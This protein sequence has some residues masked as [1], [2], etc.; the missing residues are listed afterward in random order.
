M[1]PAYLLHRAA[2]RSAT[3]HPED[4]LLAARRVRMCANGPP[5]SHPSVP[6]RVG[7]QMLHESHRLR[8]HRGVYWCTT[9]RQ[10]A[11]HAAGKKSR[12]NRFRQ[13]VPRVPDLCRSRR[14]GAHRKRTLSK[15]VSEL[16]TDARYGLNQQRLSRLSHTRK[17]STHSFVS[18]VLRQAG[19]CYMRAESIALACGRWCC[20]NTAKQCSNFARTCGTFGETCVASLNFPM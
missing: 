2:P 13:L 15:S 20:G 6:V 16:A 1:T 7:H 12:A 10:I 19:S 18:S 5:S 11:Q 4:V 3:A 9:C 17:F 8:F 14:A